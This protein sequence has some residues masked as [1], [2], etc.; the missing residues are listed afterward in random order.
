VVFMAKSSCKHQWAPLLAKRGDKLIP[1]SV[2][3]VC[4]KC[5]MLK[6]GKKTIRISRFRIDMGNKPIRNVSRIYINERLKIPVGTNLY[7]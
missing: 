3:K 1:L 5:G 2:L 7:E 4:L 6:V